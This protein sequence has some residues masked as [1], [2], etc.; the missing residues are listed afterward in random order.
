VCNSRR[1]TVDL[2][3]VHAAMLLVAMG[4]ST[5]R[6]H[7]QQAPGPLQV[8]EEVHRPPARPPARPSAP[9]GPCLQTRTPLSLCCVARTLDMPVNILP[10]YHLVPRSRKRCACQ[11][12]I[13]H[14]ME[15]MDCM[16]L[17]C[18]PNAGPR[19]KVRVTTCAA[20][21]NTRA[22]LRTALAHSPRTP[23]HAIKKYENVA[24]LA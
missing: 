23:G 3:C 11:K 14:R 18:R 5:P 19:E 13:A 24:P 12:A 21:H 6:R 8:L 1:D 4:S 20:S 15:A 22:S 7:A 16:Q 2:C 17:H 9:P 10:R